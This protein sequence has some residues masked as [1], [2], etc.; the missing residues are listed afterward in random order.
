[1]VSGGNWTDKTKKENIATYTLFSELQGDIQLSE[2]SKSNIASFK[3]Q[4]QSLPK[5]HSKIPSIKEKPLTDL[6][7]E[8]HDFDTISTTTINKHLNIISTLLNWGV[9]NNLCQ[10]NPAIGI[11]IKQ[12]R[13]ARGSRQPFSNSELSQI[14][15]TDIYT[16]K[17]YL[18]SHYF[19]LPLLALFTGAR[20]NELCQLDIS[21]IK[22]KNGIMYISINDN[23]DKTL[24]NSASFRDI[25]IHTKLIEIGF[26]DYVNTNR[27]GKS[28]QKLFSEIQKGR[29]GY[30]TAPSKW[31]QRFK[32]KLT[33]ECPEKKVFH[34]FRHNFSFAMK[35]ADI[36]T[37][38]AK[39]LIGHSEESMTYG[40][41]GSSA[42]LNQLKDNLEKIK[43]DIPEIENLKF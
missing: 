15:S 40:V 14:F 35:Q 5:N 25:P 41:Y 9:K 2:I 18:Y 12:R 30:G 37:T 26:L 32:K 21:D 27:K 23:D 38:I 42:Q 39:Q 11:K 29:E 34:S 28:Q 19:W 7:K 10:D 8:N 31:F 36:P 13:S 16:Q 20:L 22:E 6:L 4:L 24:K 17:K 3:Q 43:Y 1:M 33:L